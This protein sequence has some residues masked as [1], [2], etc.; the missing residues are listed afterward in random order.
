VDPAVVKQT[1]WELDPRAIR[2]IEARRYGN[3]ELA[4]RE[5]A[6]LLRDPNPGLEALQLAVDVAR[7]RRVED[8]DAD[9]AME[10]I[11]ETAD[12][13]FAPLPKF[14]ARAASF[15]ERSGDRKWALEL[16]ERLYEDDPGSTA[17]VN[18]LMKIGALRRFH[19]DFRGAREALTKARTHPACTAEWVPSIEARLAQLG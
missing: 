7:D 12:D 17:A 14:L 1:T 4:Q 6:S 16:Y 10:F 2:A 15:V 18:A 19:G 8:K 11:R 5:L 13:R 9:L 3:L